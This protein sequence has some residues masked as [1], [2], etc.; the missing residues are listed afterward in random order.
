MC[1]SAIPV[2]LFFWSKNPAPLL[3]HLSTLQERG[4][5]CYIQYT[6]NDYEVDGLEP[7]VAPLHQRME[8]FRR[9]VDAL[10]AGAVVWRFDPLILLTE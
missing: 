1:R 4:M 3:P 5:G 8:T 7:N 2:S 6:L 9:L 10:G